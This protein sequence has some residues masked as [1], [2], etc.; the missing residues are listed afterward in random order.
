MGCMFI[1][2]RSSEPIAVRW[3]VLNWHVMNINW[4][5]SMRLFSTTILFMGYKMI[6]RTRV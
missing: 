3:I 5:K 2:Q 1:R 6:L 4:I